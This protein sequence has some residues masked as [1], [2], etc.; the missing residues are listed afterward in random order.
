MAIN[1]ETQYPGKIAPSSPDY[2]FGQA[3]NITIPSD[4][5][6]TPWEAALV[7]D[8]FG[9]QQALLTE[10]GIVPTGSPEK[11]TASQYLTAIV[12]VTSARGGYLFSTVADMQTGTPQGGSPGDVEPAV[13]SVSMTLGYTTA[14]DG[15]GATYFKAPLATPVRQGVDFSVVDG[16][17]I[18]QGGTIDVRQ[19]GAVVG[20]SGDATQGLKDAFGSLLSVHIPPGLWVSTEKLTVNPAQVVTTG[21]VGSWI[22]GFTHLFDPDFD[23]S[24]TI[25]FKGTG[26][27]TN[28][29]D[30]I[31]SQVEFGGELADPTFA[32]THRLIDLTNNN[33]VGIQRATVK[34]FSVALELSSGCRVGPLRILPWATGID[35]YLSDVST[36][37]GDDWDVGVLMENVAGAT[38]DNVQSVG[39]WK[40]AGCLKAQTGTVAAPYGGENN[41][42][43]D[44]IFQGFRGH[45]IRSQDI[46]PVLS[47]TV[48]TIVIP[49]GLGHAFESSGV[50]RYLGVDYSYDVLSFAASQLTFNLS[51]GEDA[52]GLSLTGFLRKAGGNFGLA[53]DIYYGCHF[54][55]FEHLTRRIFEDILPATVSS[56]PLEMHGEPLRGPFFFGQTLQTHENLNAY[57]H[58][59]RDV[60]LD[61]Y[62]EGKS[63]KTGGG[64]TALDA[65]ARFIAT[66][67]NIGTSPVGFTANFRFRGERTSVD[68][69]PEFPLVGGRF[70]DAGIFTPRDF[71]SDGDMAPPYNSG[72]GFQGVTMP[73]TASSLRIF[74]DLVELMRLANSGI[75]AFGSGT[76]KFEAIN[77][78]LMIVN[79]KSGTAISFRHGGTEIF[80]T[81]PGL[82]AVVPGGDG[83][84]NLGD[85]VRRWKDI[86]AT[87]GTIIT[88]DE[89]LKVIDDI[90]KNLIDAAR[91][92]KPVRFRWRSEVTDGGDKARWHIGYSAQ[93]VFKTCQ[94]HDI[95]PFDYA[96]A[97]NDLMREELENGQYAPM[98]DDDGQPMERLG[99]RISELHTLILSAIV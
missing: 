50:V 43:R 12:R 70:N 58:H 39:Y 18:F 61:G 81:S 62:L 37:T 83:I 49:F 98:L 96:F 45:A 74:S 57:L 86:F 90:P 89:R 78:S 84:M 71:I 55:G 32:T 59:C 76:V 30:N 92:F 8:L 85:T 47:T 52:S 48:S 46:Y 66:K 6:G 10:A 20:I 44:C 67:A 80:S 16:V 21:G 7:N 33:A 26:T 36:G 82:S 19:A 64:A 22:V 14:G 25:V 28:T 77:S 31:S 79:S 4:G 99:L 13:G 95:D 97:C 38:L 65:G 24:T 51:V 2:P 69:G 88:S 40:M 15:G 5:T 11:A 72:V 54:G 63:A 34:L 73:A 9:W 53:G 87:N 56:G 94:N 68:F 3:R 60:L 41:A 29:L 17:Y 93:Q 75:E 23:T 1:P 35:D 42:F 27:K 91:Q